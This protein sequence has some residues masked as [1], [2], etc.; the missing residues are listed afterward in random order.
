MEKPHLYP[1]FRPNEE[2]PQEEKQPS[3]SPF[4]LKLPQILTGT[5]GAKSNKTRQTTRNLN[6]HVVTHL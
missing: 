1:L 2:Q 6:Y 3:A 4:F 5:K